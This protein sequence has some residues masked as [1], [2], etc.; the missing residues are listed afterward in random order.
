MHTASRARCGQPDQT[1]N[2]RSLGVLIRFGDLKIL[3]L[4]DLTW[5]KERDC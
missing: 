5:D 3:D 2:A 1:E 4:G